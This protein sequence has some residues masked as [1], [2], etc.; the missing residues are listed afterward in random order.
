MKKLDEE[1]IN[2]EMDAFAAELRELFFA[3]SNN[4]ESRRRKG[5]AKYKRT[6]SNEFPQYWR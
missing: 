1:H 6:R 4:R 3:Y 5:G 2:R